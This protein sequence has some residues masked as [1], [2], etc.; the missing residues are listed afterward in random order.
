[1]KVTVESGGSGCIH[2]PFMASPEHH[3]VAAE[4]FEYVL[5]LI[6]CRSIA[7]S[8]ILILLVLV[9]AVRRGD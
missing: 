4:E 1:M 6:Q 8:S 3:P 5:T 2:E 7:F 9:A